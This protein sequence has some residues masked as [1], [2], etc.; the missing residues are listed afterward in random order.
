MFK[1]TSTITSSP[2]RSNRRGFLKNLLTA[3]TCLAGL[4]VVSL[5][6]LSK[7]FASPVTSTSKSDLNVVSSAHPQGAKS[8][9]FGEIRQGDCTIAPGATFTLFSDGS[10]HWKCTISS[11]DSGDEWRG[12]FDITNAQGNV[13]ATTPGYHFDISVENQSRN[14]D[15]RRG[16]N[17][18]LSNAFP[19]AHGISFHCEC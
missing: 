2:L 18:A 16:G 7:D 14:W 4:S 11:S 10:T 6:A 17:A 9:S 12:R 1:D 8:W 3:G 15:E 5:K 13:L 19:G